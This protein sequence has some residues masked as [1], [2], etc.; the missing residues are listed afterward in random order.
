MTLF[1]SLNSFHYSPLNCFWFLFCVYPL[2]VCSLYWSYPKTHSTKFHYFMGSRTP[3]LHRIHKLIFA[4]F[5]KNHLFL[6]LFKSYKVAPQLPCMFRKKQPSNEV[7]FLFSPEMWVEG[8]QEYGRN[9]DSLTN[10]WR[11]VTVLW[12]WCYY[13]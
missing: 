3:W 10:V 11:H 2:T 4:I 5:I 8:K 6:Q 12:R 9:F 13:C 1:H 7:I